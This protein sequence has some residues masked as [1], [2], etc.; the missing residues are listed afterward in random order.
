V[1]GLPGHGASGGID[2]HGS[3][4]GA[5]AIAG[6]QF[7]GLGASASF[8]QSVQQLDVDGDGCDDLL[9]GDPGHGAGGAVDIVFGSPTGISLTGGLRI[10]GLSAGDD[11]GTAVAV[12]RYVPVPEPA[13]T[14]LW[15]GAPGR[16]VDG[17]AAA[18][19]VDH[20][21]LATT[22]A[23]TLQ[24]TITEDAIPALPQQLAA[25]GN[26][27]GSVLAAG[28]DWPEPA[29]LVGVP[30]ETVDGQAQAG[31]VYY[32]N[33]LAF[34]GSRRV[35]QNTTLRS[36]E[37]GEIAY[38]GVAEAGDHFGASLAFGQVAAIGVPDEDIGTVRDAGM[39][40]L[41]RINA[42]YGE[43]LAAFGSITQDTRGVPGGSEAGDHFGTS[44]AS[45]DTSSDTSQIAIGVPGEDLGDIRDAGDVTLA[46]VHP[47]E[48]TGWSYTLLTQGGT[49]RL[50]G[51]RETGD[52]VGATVADQGLAQGMPLVNRNLV[53][54]VPGE[55][56]G[57]VVDAGVTLIHKPT[58]R[59]TDSYGY[60]GGATPGLHY[61]QSLTTQITL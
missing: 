32:I 48:T 25:A 11:Y 60:S 29:L 18:G 49:G 15:I 2:V 57:Q 45:R 7:A 30:N 22:G 31:A 36:P 40:Q 1:V 19:A 54:G 27:F 51:A 53:I 37:Q 42:I 26:R 35:T 12:D 10:D 6:S 16:M 44:V 3:S 34:G 56:L 41:A 13:I 46:T 55:D 50:G 5:H 43:T 9:I 4:S 61:G 52:H 38:A 24:E 8:G 39:V 20:Y 33:A 59:S 28:V 21:T 14:D 23:V 17:L 47:F 58:T